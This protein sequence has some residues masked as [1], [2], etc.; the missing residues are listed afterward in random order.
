MTSTSSGGASVITLR[1][2]QGL[3]LD[4]SE[5][6]VRDLTQAAP[7]SSGSAHVIAPL[8]LRGRIKIDVP[9]RPG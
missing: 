7:T 8:V 5:R 9:V 3:S 6:E 1:F 4:I 2:T